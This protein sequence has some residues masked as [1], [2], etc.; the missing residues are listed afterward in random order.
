MDEP[1]APVKLLVADV[2]GTLLD[3]EKQLTERVRQSVLR[4]KEAGVLFTI[5]SAR[6]PRAVQFLIDALEITEPLACFN[7][8]LICTPRYEVLSETL[9]EKD[10]ASHVATMILDH[11]LD[12]WIFRGAEWFV[13]RLNGPHVEGHVKALGHGPRYLGPDYTMCRQANKLVGVS[14]NYAEVKRCEAEVLATCGPRISA[15]RSADYYLD[16]T[17]RDANKGRAVEVLAA[18]LKVPL[19]NV[20]T[21]GDMPTDALMFAK[22]GISIAMGNASDEVKAAA[23]FKTTNNSE[24]GFAH[25]MEE[26]V[27]PRVAKAAGAQR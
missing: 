12:L 10:D 24:D 9:L 20:A 5:I 15:T 13:S 21:I 19:E 2:D 1:T 11:G 23:K 27:L 7:G 18:M 26:I 25:A 4:V 17:H 14:D 16:V 6:P 3:P 8:A 22:T